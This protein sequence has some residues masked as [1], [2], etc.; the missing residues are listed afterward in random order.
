MIKQNRRQFLKN[1]SPLIA[2]PWLNTKSIFNSGPDTILFN[3]NII[4]VDPNNPKAQAVA[5]VGEKVVAIGENNQILK[6]ANSSKMIRSSSFS[7]VPFSIS[8]ILED[9]T[10]GFVLSSNCVL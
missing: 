6:L 3:A 2:L 8:K 5:I 9:L 10:S 7:S 1:A 4:T